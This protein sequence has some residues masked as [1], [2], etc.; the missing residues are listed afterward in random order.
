MNFN[1]SYDLAVAHILSKHNLTF[2]AFCGN[3]NQGVP[4][5][6]PVEYMAVHGTFNKFRRNQNSFKI[7][8]CMDKAFC[9][10]RFDPHLFCGDNEEFLKNLCRN[11][12]AILF[13]AFP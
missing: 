7:L 4:K 10:K 6:N 3:D 5:R 12:P 9:S 11:N 8:K 1:S 13:S 2:G